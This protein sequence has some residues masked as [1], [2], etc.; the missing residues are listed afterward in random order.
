MVHLYRTSNIVP[1]KAYGA[2][3][4]GRISS[5][6]DFMLGLSLLGDSRT[7][8]ISRMLRETCSMSVQGSKE[9]EAGFFV[10]RGRIGE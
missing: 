4:C 7:S 5:F 9:Q 2:I 10:G 1:G 8:I 6:L 3:G